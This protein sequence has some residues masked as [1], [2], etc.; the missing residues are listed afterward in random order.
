MVNAITNDIRS[1]IKQGVGTIAVLCKTERE[2][3][4]LAKELTMRGLGVYLLDEDFET[5]ETI[6]IASISQV[7]GLEF[8]AVLL[9]N[10]RDNNFPDTWTYNRLLYLAITRA[11]HNLHVHWFGEIAQILAPAEFLKTGKSSTYSDNVKSNKLKA[12]TN[13]EIILEEKPS[14]KAKTPWYK[15]IFGLSD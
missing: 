11:A 13:R 8:D 9:S 1:L 5:E 12:I 3:R 2:S 10:A 7:K 6:F 4:R 15:R 14:N